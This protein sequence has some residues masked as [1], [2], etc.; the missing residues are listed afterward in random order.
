MSGHTPTRYI[1]CNVKM[2]GVENGQ[3]EILDT[4]IDGG[5]GEP[6]I[7]ARF[8]DRDEAKKFCA[9]VNS[10]AD[11]VGVATM[12]RLFARGEAKPTKDELLSKID[13]ALAK[14][15]VQA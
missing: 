3:T 2:N 10:H 14:A 13:A 4:T 1:T 12:L 8:Y 7:V 9:A 6:L 11:L 15:G 5:E